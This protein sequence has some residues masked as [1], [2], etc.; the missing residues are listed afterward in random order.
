AN[1]HSS[2]WSELL[3]ELRGILLRVVFLA[4]I[5]SVVLV[6]SELWR[7]ATYRYVRDVHRRSQLHWVRKIVVWIVVGAIVAFSFV[8]RLGSIATFAGLLTAA[9]AF[10]LQ[11][12]IQS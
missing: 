1:W 11:N 8:S 7:R 3:A 6:A 5:L 4:V 12:V 2:A 9:I 10:A